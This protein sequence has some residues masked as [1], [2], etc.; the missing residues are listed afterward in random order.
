MGIKG[1][2][3][4]FDGLILD[5]ELPLYEAW[6]EIYRAYDLELPLSEWAKALGASYEAFDPCVY[7]EELTGLSMDREGLRSKGTERALATMVLQETLPGV[8]EYLALGKD[9]GLKLGLA[10]SSGQEWVVGHIT[11]LGLLPFFDA[12]CTGDEVPKVKPDPA[13][14][15]CALQKLGL[16]PEEALAFEDSPN[17]IT[18]AKAAGMY[19]IAVPNTLTG[20]L[21]VGHA[22]L[23]IESMSAISLEQLLS[24]F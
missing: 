19:C 4:D 23:V 3:F 15:R 9:Y 18:A 14:Y 20:Q 13:L 6:Q 7:L 10:S 16:A 8:R 2:V 5:T 17:G 22:D 1:L 12:I 24:Q 11:R 21:N